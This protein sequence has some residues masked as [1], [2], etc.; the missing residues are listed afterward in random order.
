MPERI[1]CRGTSSIGPPLDDRHYRDARGSGDLAGVRPADHQPRPGA[2]VDP[3]VRTHLV[4]DP[5]LDRRLGQRVD[6]TRY[7]GA[8]GGAEVLDPPAGAV[9]G[10]LGVPTADSV[11]VAA[12][13]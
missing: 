9:G 3:V 13:H 12:V 10:E 8:V 6:R 1:N 7:E 2:D 4:L 5:R 11:V